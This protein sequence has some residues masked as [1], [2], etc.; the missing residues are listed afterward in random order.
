MEGRKAK[1]KKN[2]LQNRGQKIEDRK[3]RT[4]KRKSGRTEEGGQRRKT[5]ALRP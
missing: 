2:L 3:G 4:E 1:K 5:I